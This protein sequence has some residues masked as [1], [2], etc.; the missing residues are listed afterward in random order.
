MMIRVLGT[1]LVLALCVSLVGAQEKREDNKRPIEK[2]E[3]DK[4]TP[5]DKD[6]LVAI[7]SCCNFMDRTLALVEKRASSDKVKDFA[8]KMKEDHD[9]LSKD[10]GTTIKDKKLAVVAGLDKEKNEKITALGKLEKSEFD[11]AFLKQVVEGHEKVI[12]MAD[13]QVAKGTD[14]DITKFA[15]DMLPTLK[16]HLK[17]AKELQKDIK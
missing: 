1:T 6:F 7:H 8:K 16:D 12:K 14:K 10:L 13:H 15:K 11:T 17:K 5:L 3:F 2:K 9:K 4:E